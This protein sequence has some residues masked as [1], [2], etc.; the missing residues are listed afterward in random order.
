MVRNI[1]GDH[2]AGAHKAVFPDGGSTYDGTVGPQGR[3]VFHEGVGADLV[4]L[5]D[6][7]PWVID[8]GK[9]H[10]RSA[11]NTVFQGNAFVNGDIV[12]NFTPFPNGDIGADYHVLPDIAVFAQGC[13]GQDMGKMP[14]FG[15]FADFAAVVDDR[16]FVNK[17]ISCRL[18][19]V[20]CQFHPTSSVL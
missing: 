17:E 3:A 10:G 18:P 4:H 2:G 15:A 11:E 14:D 13:V 16:G 19:V 7:G 5:A 1:V 20:G 8:V 9:D 12:L 6:F